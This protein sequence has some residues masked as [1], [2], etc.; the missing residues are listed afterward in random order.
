MGLFDI[1]FGKKNSS[2]KRVN[3]GIT[4]SHSSPPAPSPSKISVK[5]KL[6][7]SFNEGYAR[8]FHNYTMNDGTQYSFGFP[9]NN[10]PDQRVWVG[11]DVGNSKV[12]IA[13]VS[14]SQAELMIRDREVNLLS[15]NKPIQ[16]SSYSTY[17]Y[18]DNCGKKLRGN[19]SKKH[20]YECWSDGY[21]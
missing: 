3:S 7:Y 13:R 12:E 8:D 1:L 5:P 15:H 18:C 9:Q 11:K 2:P 10:C 4:Y 19:R 6:R 14:H 21:R 20:C 16:I 17:G